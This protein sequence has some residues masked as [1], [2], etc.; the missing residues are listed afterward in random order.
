MLSFYLLLT[1]ERK[2]EPLTMFTCHVPAVEKGCV[3]AVTA[4]TGMLG[5][6][7]SPAVIRL[8]VNSQPTLT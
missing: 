1:V 7:G 3:L 2:A 4:N 6:S 8:P 5:R